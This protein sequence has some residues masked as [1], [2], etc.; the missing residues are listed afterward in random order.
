MSIA[1]D[2][3]FMI[4]GGVNE[5]TEVKSFTL[6]QLYK[7]IGSLSSPEEGKTR[8]QV[9]EERIRGFMYEAN[10]KMILVDLDGVIFD[11]CNRVDLLPKTEDVRGSRS[12][13]F[14]LPYHNACGIDEVIQ[15]NVKLVQMLA[16]GYLDDND[17]PFV[18]GLTSRIWSPEIAETTHRKLNDSGLEIDNV[19][20]RHPDNPVDPLGMKAQFCELLNLVKSADRVT[21]I[22]DNEDNFQLFKGLGFTSIKV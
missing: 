22:E 13:D 5:F 16:A 20:M 19:W 10:F 4:L 15:K 18:V 14:Y 7:E 8:E 17:S 6:S 1:F 9:G 21:T 11:D 12:Q 3:R 2:N